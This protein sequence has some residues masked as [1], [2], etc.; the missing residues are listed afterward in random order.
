[1]NT[2]TRSL[3]AAAVVAVG[4]TAAV[5]AVASAAPARCTQ[6]LLAPQCAHVLGAKMRTQLAGLGV[7]RPAVTNVTLGQMAAD[8]CV[9]NNVRDHLATVMVTPDFRISHFFTAANR[10][11]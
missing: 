7:A 5:P 3:L 2:R 4:L 9:H 10:I 8:I 11:C 6:Y 1:M